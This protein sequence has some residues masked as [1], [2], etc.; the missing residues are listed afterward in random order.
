MLKP[1]D[2]VDWGVDIIRWFQQFSPTLDLPFKSLTFLG[3][4][5]FFL[6]LI[7]KLFQTV[8]VFCRGPDRLFGYLAWA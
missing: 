5:E 8:Y 3:N 7:W 2:I 6:V 1:E 4:L